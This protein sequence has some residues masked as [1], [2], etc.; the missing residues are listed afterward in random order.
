MSRKRKG[1]RKHLYLLAACAALTGLGFSGC[2]LLQESF[3]RPD[4]LQAEHQ[5]SNGNFQTSLEAYSQI[6]SVYPQAADEAHFEIGF[7]LAHP[8]NP[9]RDYQKS[10]EA[11]RRL[12]SEYPQ[13][14]Y[15]VPSE[16]AAALVTELINQE[17]RALTCPGP[18]ASWSGSTG[19][20]STSSSGKP[21]GRS[22]TLRWRN[23]RRAWISGSSSTTTRGL[24]GATATWVDGPLK[25]SKPASL[26]ESRGS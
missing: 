14:Q 24:I 1:K 3:A 18:T 4:Y 11:F 2:A 25:P 19:P 23:S 15:R 7:I 22:S 12:I 6:V 26:S 17:K 20:S 16:M 8:K 5:L 13:S 21:S 10:L 9:N